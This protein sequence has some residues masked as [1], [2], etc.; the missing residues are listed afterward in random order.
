VSRA[1]SIE[2]RQYWFRM[3]Q[4]SRTFSIRAL[5][6]GSTTLEG[7]RSAVLE[8]GPEANLALLRYDD[9]K[10]SFPMV[11]PN[12]GSVA[13]SRLR[14]KRP[15]LIY[16]YNTGDS[17]NYIEP[18]IEVLEVPFCESCVRRHGAEQTTP[19]P[20]TPLKRI[21]SESEGF[22]GLVAVAISSLFFSS[23]IAPFR[24]APLILG[25][26]PLMIGLWLIRRVWKK[27]DHMS[28]PQPTSVDSTF[29]FTPYLGLAHE[30]PWRAFQF[31]SAE[32]A[33]K[34]RSANA[35]RLWSPH[36]DEAKSA[37][38]LRAKDEEKSNRI[39]W[40]F[41]GVLLLW[42]LWSEVLKDVVLPWFGG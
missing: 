31:R 20:W 23:A 8:A 12:C 3:P 38:A 14:I 34:F 35:E 29:D 41:G 33:E 22:A 25:S 36:G 26:L 15:F 37:A 16:V 4:A 17:G 1:Q 24:L 11:C 40:L 32:Y 21:L 2:K 42:F 13:D 9:G 5:A 6:R 28:L 39:A 18:S 30:P 19:G 10:L 7:L 27:S